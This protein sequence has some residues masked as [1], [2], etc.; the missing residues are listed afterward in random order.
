MEV[1]R[2]FF[3]ALVFLLLHHGANSCRMTGCSGATKPVI[4]DKLHLIDFH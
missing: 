1:L 3:L 4:A 2:F